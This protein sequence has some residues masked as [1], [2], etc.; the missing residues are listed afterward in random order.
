MNTKIIEEK[1]HDKLEST[2]KKLLGLT[3]IADQ[4]K[5]EALEFCA[6]H[7]LEFGW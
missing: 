2:S 5:E 7:N 3:N 4:Y 1:F 6:E